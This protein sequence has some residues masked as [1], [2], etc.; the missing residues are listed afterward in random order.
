MISPAL[1][2]S[3]LNENSIQLTDNV[4]KQLLS[5]LDLMLRW[6]KAFNLTSITSPRDMI[7]LH[8]IDSLIVA[9]YMKGP[10]CLD[11]GTGAGLPG[12][13]LA[14]INPAQQWTLLDKNNKKTRFLTQV[15]ADLGL[16]NVH[17]IH[18]RSENFQSTS[19][20]DTITSRAFGSLAL[21]AQIT[22]HLLKPEGELI[23]MKGKYPED[24]ISELAT[25]DLPVQ[26]S[27][28]SVNQI[29]INGTDVDRHIVCLKS[30]RG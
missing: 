11:I 30:E 26:V 18:Q 28:Q 14:L 12:I 23:A 10:D 29:H 21:F 16:N 24:E 27:V 17:V 20:F 4:Q 9:P 25:G 3:A 13:P 1:L 2:Q 6:N 19:G 8:L 7:Y 15:V 5:Y 22:A